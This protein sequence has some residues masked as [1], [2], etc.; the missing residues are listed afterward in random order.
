ML[1]VDFDYHSHIHSG[2]L[3]VC[4]QVGDNAI[5]AM[6]RAALA[7]EVALWRSQF[8]AY[9]AFTR[10]DFNKCFVAAFMRVQ[11]HS[12]DT[13]S[14]THHT[15]SHTNKH[16]HHCVRKTYSLNSWQTQCQRLPNRKV[17][18]MFMHPLSPPT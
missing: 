3:R 4:L 1:C 9:I 2:V 18:R 10:N 5:N 15:Y 17:S 7:K 16:I 13:Y 11:V 8:G 6:L 14:Y 12:Q